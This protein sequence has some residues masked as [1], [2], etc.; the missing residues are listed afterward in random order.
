MQIGTVDRIAA[1]LGIWVDLTGR[2]R[3]GEGDRLLSRRHSLLA[4][5]VLRFL[6]TVPGWVVESE[7]SSSIYGRLPTVPTR[8]FG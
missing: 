2:W 5:D 1:I 8:P 3:G 6:Q 4:D 7:V